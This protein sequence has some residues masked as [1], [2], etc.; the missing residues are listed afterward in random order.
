MTE[1]CPPH[2]LVALPRHSTYSCWLLT[3]VSDSACSSTGIDNL[4]PLPSP[5]MGCGSNG[6]LFIIFAILSACLHSFPFVPSSNLVQ[7][8]HSSSQLH[9]QFRIQLFHIFLQLQ[10]WCTECWSLGHWSLECFN[11]SIY[12]RCWH[13]LPRN[14]LLWYQM[15]ESA[16][17][18]NKWW[19]RTSE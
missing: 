5:A 14:R 4:T 16:Q 18:I 12:S 6:K 3:I 13:P 19:R 15:I 10:H 1:R 2:T 11:S 9:P 17:I 8:S 7:A